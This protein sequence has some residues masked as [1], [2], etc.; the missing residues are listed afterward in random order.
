MGKTN[1]I[2]KDW[3]ENLNLEN[4]DLSNIPWVSHIKESKRISFA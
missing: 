4:T 2:T 3:M 1:T